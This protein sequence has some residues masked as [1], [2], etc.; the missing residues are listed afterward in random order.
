MAQND[1]S[2]IIE[3]ARFLFVDDFRHDQDYYAIM[4]KHIEHADWNNFVEKLVEDI[5]KNGRWSNIDVIGKIYVTEQWL[6]KLLQLIQ[7]KPSLNY[8]QHYEQYLAKD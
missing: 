8:T 3:Q 1:T 4:K 5:K 7:Q 2:K 6:Q